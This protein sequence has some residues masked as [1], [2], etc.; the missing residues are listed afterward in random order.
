MQLLWHFSKHSTF[1]ECLFFGCV[2]YIV[3][4][5]VASGWTACPWSAVISAVQMHVWGV[6]IIVKIF[7]IRLQIKKIVNKSTDPAWVLGMEHLS[8]SYSHKIHSSVPFST[9]LKYRKRCHDL[10]HIL[11]V[12]NALRSAFKTPT[13]RLLYSMSQNQML[14]ARKVMLRVEW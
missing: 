8:S 2:L 4:V 9:V 10:Y 1:Y 7:L 5:G 6:T 12:Q 11:L 14:Q 3:T 13:H